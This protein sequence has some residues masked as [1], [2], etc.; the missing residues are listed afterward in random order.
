LLGW[1]ASRFLL[2]LGHWLGR[3]SQARLILMLGLIAATVGIAMSLE[4]S[5]LIALLAFGIASR[6]RDPRRTVMEPDFSQFSALLYVLLF[7]YAG[8]R[9]EL[10]HFPALAMIV[11]AFIALRFAV[12]V[13]WTTALAPI[14]GLTWR[15][16]V[17]LGV[18]LLPLSGFKIVVLQQAAAA[19]PEFSSQ[20]SALMLSILLITEITGPIC[21]RYALIASGEAKT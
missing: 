3:D 1:L 9:L 21:T 18:A 8:A 7:V 5:A 14:N 19:Y 17:L 2:W 6:S 16:G 13:F 4:L 20:L 12:M 10:N 15:K 11:L